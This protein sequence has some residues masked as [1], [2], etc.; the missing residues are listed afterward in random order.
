L[1]PQLN[2]STPKQDEPRRRLQQRQA[3]DRKPTPGRANSRWRTSG[4]M[5]SSGVAPVGSSH[6]TATAYT[7]WRQRLGVDDRLV[8]ASRQGKGRMLRHPQPR[9]GATGAELRPAGAGHPD[10]V[11]GRAAHT[12]ARPTTAGATG[13]RHECPGNRHPDLAP[14]VWLHRAHVDAQTVAPRLG[15][16]EASIMGVRAARRRSGAV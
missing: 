14:G 7:T 16:P 2:V 10:P 15:R 6:P 5:G 4:S 3:E 8:P 9:E 12:Y 13:P 11:E 1:L